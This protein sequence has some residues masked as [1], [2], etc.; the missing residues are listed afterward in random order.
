MVKGV[1]ATDSLNSHCPTFWVYLF[2]I[3]AVRILLPVNLNTEWAIL[4]LHA[5]PGHILL[6]TFS[7]YH[8]LELNQLPN[9]PTSLQGPIRVLVCTII[10]GPILPLLLRWHPGPS[11]HQVLIKCSNGK[12]YELSSS[13]SS[14]T[15]FVWFLKSSGAL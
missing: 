1:L 9:L 2:S 13:S 4:S 5:H 14:I 12:K 3:K 8:L 6:V 10:C 7:P 15:E 11:I